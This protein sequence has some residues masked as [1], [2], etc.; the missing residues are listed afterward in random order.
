MRRGRRRRCVEV[1]VIFLPSNR[2]NDE[3][4]S[5]ST[6]TRGNGKRKRKRCRPRDHQGIA[7]LLFAIL[8]A[9]EH[10][11]APDRSYLPADGERGACSPLWYN[12]L[13]I[14][15]P[16][17]TRCRDSPYQA[18]FFQLIDG[19]MEGTYSAVRNEGWSDDVEMTGMR[20]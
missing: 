11:R 17:E 13:L 4:Q 15:A 20:D 14:S 7:L 9:G 16:V 5:L 3:H 12:A 1:D 6:V 19:I 2:S 8:H 10:G 18:L